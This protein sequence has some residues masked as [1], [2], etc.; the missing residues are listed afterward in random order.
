MAPTPGVSHIEL[1]FLQRLAGG[2]QKGETEQPQGSILRTRVMEI[3]ARA[4]GL[5][6]AACRACAA[7]DAVSAME[8]ALAFALEAAREARYARTLPTAL[9]AR[10]Q[11]EVDL[12]ISSV[13]W[14]ARDAAFGGRELFRGGESVELEG[15]RV[16]LPHLST[17]RIG[18]NWVARG[19]PWR[20]D[21]GAVE[22]SQSIAS[23]G[24]GGANS[25]ELWPEGAAMAL[26]AGLSQ[27][28]ETRSVLDEFYRS[29]VLPGI[30]EL[31]VTLS[32]AIA[33]ESVNAGFEEAAALLKDVGKNLADIL[34]KSGD[35]KGILKLLG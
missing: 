5:Q 9:L 11:A 12:A 15:H 23:V 17:E 21:T 33:A 1:E 26:E 27:M 19:E 34:P 29:K 14:H 4:E 2:V 8:E 22:Y 35:G 20:I 16:E 31:A 30:G 18:G 3:R 24:T 13:D 6:Q 25:L 28:R 32:N 10:L 7:I